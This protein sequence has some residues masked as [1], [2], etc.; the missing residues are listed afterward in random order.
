MIE[1][2]FCTNK[3]EMLLDKGNYTYM[4]NMKYGFQRNRE[5]GSF[6]SVTRRPVFVDEASAGLAR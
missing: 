6:L 2:K 4:I 5:T 1:A 3:T